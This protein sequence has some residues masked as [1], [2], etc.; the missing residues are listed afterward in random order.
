MA[1]RAFTLVELL[2]IIGILALFS[3]MLLPALCKAKLPSRATACAANFRQWA[4]SANM[5]AADFNGVL[6]GAAFYPSGG[7]GNP[8]DVGVGFTPALARYGLTAPMWFC[9][10]R[11]EETAAQYAAARSVLGHEL[12]TIDDL[13]SFLASYFGGGFVI[14]NHNLW[15]NRKPSAPVAGSLPDPSVPPTV[16]NTDPAIYG[17]PIKITDSAGAHVPFLSDACFSGYEAGNP[18]GTNVNNINITGLNAFPALVKKT[19]GHVTNGRRSSIAVNLV[20]VDGR[21]VSHNRQFIRCVY[22]GDSGSG[23]FY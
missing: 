20:F 15:V 2:V 4:V 1:R 16:A 11:T 18:G 14:M 19:S 3:T 23:W 7:G 22:I 12:A 13:N 17:W 5:Y 10:A 9:P 21:V 8:W 6:P